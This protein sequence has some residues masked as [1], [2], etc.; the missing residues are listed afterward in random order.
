[1]Q[2]VVY[3]ICSQF[4]TSKVGTNNVDLPCIDKFVLKDFIWIVELCLIC[5][6]LSL[7]WL[8][9]AD[10]LSQII[11]VKDYTVCKNNVCT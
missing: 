1:M 6:E 4:V 8:R 2:L 9:K 11:F 10:D 7:T 3:E 5:L